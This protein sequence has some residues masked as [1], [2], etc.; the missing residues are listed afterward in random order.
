MYKIQIGKIIQRQSIEKGGETLKIWI[1]LNKRS[2]VFE[3]GKLGEK[4]VNQLMSMNFEQR[5]NLIVSYFDVA[6]GNILYVN[7]DNSYLI[8]RMM[9]AKDKFVCLAFIK[10]NEAQSTSEEN[11]LR[12]LAVSNSFANVVIINECIENRELFKKY[13]V[14]AVPYFVVFVNGTFFCKFEPR[15]KFINRIKESYKL[16]EKQLALSAIRKLGV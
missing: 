13:N 3:I 10:I 15:F 2:N 7:K 8:D 9:D 4:I 5:R 6:A 12:K 14:T 16:F 1:D 11:E